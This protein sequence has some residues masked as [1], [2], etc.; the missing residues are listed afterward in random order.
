MRGQTARRFSPANA[1]V[2]PNRATK[3]P[4]R[5]TRSAGKRHHTLG[6]DTLRCAVRSRLRKDSRPRRIRRPARKPTPI[7]AANNSTPRLTRFAESL[8]FW[9][10]NAIRSRTCKPTGPTLAGRS[11]S[12]LLQQRLRNRRI[13]ARESQTL[14]LVRICV[15]ENREC[16]ARRW[17]C[18]LSRNR[19]D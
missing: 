19:G 13:C 6:A 9:A 16:E 3:P 1:F 11:E 15:N 2:D 18:A 17:R 14:E 5:S 10:R 12:S 8:I 4:R 7:S